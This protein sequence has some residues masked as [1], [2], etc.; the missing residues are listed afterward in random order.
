MPTDQNGFYIELKIT[1]DGDGVYVRSDDVPGL[2]LAGKFLK[3][4]K[5]MIEIAIRRLFKDNRGEN[6]RVIWLSN[7]ANFPMVEDVPA[8]LAIYPVSE[9]A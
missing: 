8:R 3:S 4:M 1:P 6:V 9:A 5:P 2:Y 7:I